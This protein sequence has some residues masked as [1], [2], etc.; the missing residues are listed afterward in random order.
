MTKDVKA[1]A[2]ITVHYGNERWF[3]CACEVCWEDGCNGITSKSACHSSGALW[4]G[5]TMAT[6]LSELPFTEALA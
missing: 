2:Q 5:H 1:G 6:C 3:K 4:C